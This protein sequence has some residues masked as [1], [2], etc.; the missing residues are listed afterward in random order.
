MTTRERDAQ[1]PSPTEAKLDRMVALLEQ[2]LDALTPAPQSKG[3]R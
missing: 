2:I 1:Q 3:K